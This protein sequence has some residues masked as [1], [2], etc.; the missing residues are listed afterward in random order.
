MISTVKKWRGRWRESGMWMER[1]TVWGHCWWGWEW[2]GKWGSCRAPP[3]AT[4]G[5]QVLWKPCTSP[6]WCPVLGTEQMPRSSVG[7]VEA[8][9]EIKGKPGGRHGNGDWRWEGI[10]PTLDLLYHCSRWA[11]GREHWV[12]LSQ[13]KCANHLTVSRCVQDALLWGNPFVRTAPVQPSGLGFLRWKVLIPPQD[14]VLQGEAKATWGPEPA[15]SM[16]L[17]ERDQP[18]AASCTPVGADS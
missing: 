9:M 3:C 12:N 11:Q 1:G 6:A 17:P 4:G 5:H 10:K 14:R 2:P 8:W 18:P 13:I 15:C 7:W 16:R